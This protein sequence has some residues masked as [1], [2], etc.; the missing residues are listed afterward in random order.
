MKT[1]RISDSATPSSSSSQ[2]KRPYEQ[3]SIVRISNE[4]IIEAIGPAQGYRH[5]PGIDCDMC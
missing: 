4:E 2:T 5:S 1:S 3:P